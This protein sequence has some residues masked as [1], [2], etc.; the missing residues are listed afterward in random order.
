[1]IKAV[2]F[3]FFILLMLAVS[4]Y[5]GFHHGVHG[6]L[7]STYSMRV[8]D[9]KEILSLLNHRRYEEAKDISLDFI[10]ASITSLDGICTDKVSIAE[11]PRR[12]IEYH[13]A[14]MMSK[15]SMQNKLNEAKSNYALLKDEREKSKKK[16][17][18][19]KLK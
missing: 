17:K 10:D 11:I 5:F 6:A 8:D 7:F 19:S 2:T 3:T 16:G 12:V 14:F 18:A 1:M 13:T 15:S 9:Q 4:Y